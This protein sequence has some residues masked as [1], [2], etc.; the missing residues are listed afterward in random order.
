MAL[1]QLQQSPPVRIAQKLKRTM[2]GK[3]LRRWLIIS[4]KQRSSPGHHRCVTPLNVTPM[5]IFD[6]GIDMQQICTG[7]C[8]VLCDH[9]PH[10]ALTIGSDWY[11]TLRGSIGFLFY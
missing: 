6:C 4:S 11:W 5:G 9:R 2:A 1:S 10:K 8:P 3:G 7:V